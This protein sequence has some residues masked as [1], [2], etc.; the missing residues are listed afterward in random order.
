M[1]TN[2]FQLRIEHVL[3]V[4]AGWRAWWSKWATTASTLYRPTTRAAVFMFHFIDGF[5][6]SVAVLVYWTC[7]CRYWS[8][9]TSLVSKL[10]LFTFSPVV[11]HICWHCCQVPSLLGLGIISP[12]V[13]IWSSL[14][15]YYYSSRCHWPCPMLPIVVEVEVV[16]GVKLSTP[17][18]CISGQF[19]ELRSWGYSWGCAVIVVT[20]AF[21]CRLAIPG[22]VITVR[23]WLCLLC[24]TFYC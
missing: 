14:F 23:F 12:C 1:E 18:H 20:V 4:G 7:R 19:R 8:H 21:G 11:Y 13:S 3:R 17:L 24:F 2:F 10:L 5:V 9:C 22:G 16:F 6:L 15:S